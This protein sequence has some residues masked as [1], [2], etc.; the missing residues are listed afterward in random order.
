MAR[1]RDKRDRRRASSSKRDAQHRV[2][3]DWTS[4]TLPDGVEIW[5]PKEGSH[6]L[7]IV[8]YEVGQ[9]NPYAEK[10]EW[11]YERTYFAHRQIGPNN[12][13][14]VCPAKTAGLP[15]PV[16]DHRAKLARDPDSDEKMIDALKPKERQLW[17]IYDH[18]DK[19]KGVQLW[20]FSHWNFGRLLDRTRKDADEDEMHITDFD[21][22]DAGSSLKVSFSEEK[23]GGYT[24]LEAYSINFKPRPN[25]LD[26]EILGHGLCLDDMLK[27]LPY[28]ELKAKLFQTE[29]EDEDEDDDAD[30]KPSPKKQTRKP[31]PKPK[32]DEDEDD[33][34]EDDEPAPKPKKKK[35]PVADD[36]D[37]EEGQM[38]KHGKH[39]ICEIV[40]ISGDGTSLTLEDEEDERYCGIG[41]D[42]VKP[43]KKKV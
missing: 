21:D 14:Y 18:K 32:V 11:Y 6:R 5:Q 41:P 15:C 7:D 8:P 39:G 33:D 10:G 31:K 19:D 30:E 3:G 36:F 40:R 9:G 23:G 16:C 22:P 20:D 24:Y 25:G 29:E 1:T 4:L 12:E 42:E 35:E 43:I 27:V 38:V 28:D 34:D 37:L 17:L 26:E 13:T 2:G